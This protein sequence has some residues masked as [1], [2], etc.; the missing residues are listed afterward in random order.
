MTE[1]VARHIHWMWS[2]SLLDELGV[3]VPCGDAEEW[4]APTPAHLLAEVAR[5]VQLPEDCTTRLAQDIAHWM[6]ASGGASGEYDKPEGLPNWEFEGY[7]IGDDGVV[8]LGGV[9]LG[10]VEAVTGDAEWFTPEDYAHL[11]EKLL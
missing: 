7:T 10:S 11:R 1:V 8:D 5:V 4:L 9:P 3:R 2:C 6:L